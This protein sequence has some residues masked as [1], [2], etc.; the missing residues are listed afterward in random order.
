VEEAG[1]APFLVVVAVLEDRPRQH[2]VEVVTVVEAHQVAHHQQIL[3]ETQEAV[4]VVEEEALH[5]VVAALN[6]RHQ[7][8]SY[9]IRALQ[10]V[11]MQHDRHNP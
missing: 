11:Q 1:A 3:V 6:N 7:V 4:A 2:L 9:C 8:E 5:L 10:L